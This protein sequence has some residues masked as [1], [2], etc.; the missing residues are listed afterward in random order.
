MTSEHPPESLRSLGQ[1]PPPPPGLISSTARGLS[2][3][4]ARPLDGRFRQ[5]LPDCF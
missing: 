1:P 5:R 2:Y 3:K 4:Y